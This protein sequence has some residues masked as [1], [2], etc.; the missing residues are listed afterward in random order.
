MG[1]GEAPF[2]K[3]ITEFVGGIFLV[4][5]FSCMLLVCRD[6]QLVESMRF[7]YLDR[8]VKEGNTEIVLPQLPHDQLLQADADSNYWKYYTDYMYKTDIHV[9]FAEWYVWLNNKDRPEDK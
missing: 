5:S 3:A 7:K 4:I 6:W 1:G 8:M 2:N 9:S